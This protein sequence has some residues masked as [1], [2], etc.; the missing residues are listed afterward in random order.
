MQ[1]VFSHNL[2]II[3]KIISS[4]K[5]SISYLENFIF[6]TFFKTSLA[7]NLIATA[8]PVAVTIRSLANTIINET[9]DLLD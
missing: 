4:F 2:L 3:Y 9:I 6:P 5:I 8:V 1:S 7:K